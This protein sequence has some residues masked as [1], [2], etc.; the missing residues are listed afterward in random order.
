MWT[1]QLCIHSYI[2]YHSSL[3]GVHYCYYLTPVQ[4]AVL[5]LFYDFI[6]SAS[7]LSACRFAAIHRPR[8]IHLRR[9]PSRSSLPDRHSFIYTS[10]HDYFR[11]TI[12]LT[13]TITLPPSRFRK[14]L[15]AIVYHYVCRPEKNSKTPDY[16][17]TVYIYI[18]IRTLGINSFATRG[19]V[20]S[21]CSYIDCCNFFSFCSRKYKLWFSNW[22][23]VVL[24]LEND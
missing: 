5:N 22:A 8:S 4:P 23:A 3:L 19:V 7:H 10:I 17:Q 14:T 15:M 2:A 9:S 24:I 16:D 21:L 11:H 12:A 18:Y 6:D 20:F 1:T 13:H